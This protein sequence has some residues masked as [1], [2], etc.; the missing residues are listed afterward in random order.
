MLLYCHHRNLF[1]IDNK[2][3]AMLSSSSIK[4]RSLSDMSIKSSLEIEEIKADTQ[5]AKVPK[6]E[7][8]SPVIFARNSPLR[9]S[10]PAG[11]HWDMD[12]SSSQIVRSYSVSNHRP[13]SSHGRTSPVVPQVSRRTRSSENLTSVGNSYNFNKYNNNNT[14]KLKSPF[15]FSLATPTSSLTS[16]KFLEAKS[17]VTAGQLKRTSRRSLDSADRPFSAL[18]SRNG[19]NDRRSF[20]QDHHYL[21]TNC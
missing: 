6:L 8:R 14:S 1:G 21:G 9:A 16:F 13:I 11:N 20:Q 12:N 3:D 5:Q 4:R 7:I 18:P 17:K 19:V 2:A 15:S 10:S